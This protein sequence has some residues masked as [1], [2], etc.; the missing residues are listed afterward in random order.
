MYLS[1]SLVLTIMIDR[2]GRKQG[3]VDEEE[4]ELNDDDL[5]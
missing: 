1:W 5:M 4:D 2:G 3:D